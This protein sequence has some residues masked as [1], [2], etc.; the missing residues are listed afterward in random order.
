VVILSFLYSVV[1]LDPEVLARSDPKHF[2]RVG[3]GSGI[4]VP[5]PASDP[6]P[7]PTFSLIFNF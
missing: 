3:S 5:G 2:G 4:C 7:D 6:R 1:D